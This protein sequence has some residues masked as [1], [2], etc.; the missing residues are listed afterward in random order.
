MEEPFEFE[1]FAGWNWTGA[2]ERQDEMDSKKMEN[3]FP[4][5]EGNLI[6]GL[7]VPKSVH[8]FSFEGSWATEIQGENSQ[9]V[10][11][12]SFELS[13]LRNDP[14]YITYTLIMVTLFSAFPSPSQ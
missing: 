8:L 1:D 7:C 3:E 12:T 2:E 10:T 13:A 4:Y 9:P 6:N 5:P 14:D 11:R